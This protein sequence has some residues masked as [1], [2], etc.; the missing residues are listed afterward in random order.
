MSDETVDLDNLQSD[1][2][3]WIARAAF[4]RGALCYSHGDTR[5][6][7]IEKTVTQCWPI[8]VKRLR[9]VVGSNGWR[10]RAHIYAD[11]GW[12]G[13]E[14]CWRGNGGWWAAGTYPADVAAANLPGNPWEEVEE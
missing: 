2:E 3:R 7:E 14:T 10:Y 9:E 1:R 8:K 4:R 13:V 5:M 12:T 11:T 6:E